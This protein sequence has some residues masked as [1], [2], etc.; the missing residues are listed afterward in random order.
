M[1]LELTKAQRRAELPK[2]RPTRNQLG[3]LV[4]VLELVNADLDPTEI[5]IRE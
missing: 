1:R 5:R 3:F 2:A 4:S